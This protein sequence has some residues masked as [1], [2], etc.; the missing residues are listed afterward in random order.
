LSGS[1]L[2]G[3]RLG[4]HRGGRE[5]PA[6]SR[7]LH[8]HVGR[9]S[10]GHDRIQGRRRRVE[11]RAPACGPDHDNPI[12]RVR[13]WLGRMKPRGHPPSPGDRDS[14]ELGDHVGSLQK[15]QSQRVHRLASPRQRRRSR[16]RNW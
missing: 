5:L 12:A 6:P 7:R 13:H 8:R 14:D 4:L 11:T 10:S 1:D 16:S 2:Q 9:E 15:S 3:P